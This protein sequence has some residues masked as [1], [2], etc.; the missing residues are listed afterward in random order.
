MCLATTPIAGV[1]SGLWENAAVVF[2]TIVPS[3]RPVVGG[4]R[5]YDIDAVSRATITMSAAVKLPSR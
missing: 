3:Q 5:R 4:K 1:A 2:D